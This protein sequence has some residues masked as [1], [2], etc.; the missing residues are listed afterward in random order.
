MNCRY[1]NKI[2]VKLGINSALAAD[3]LLKELMK[4]AVYRDERYWIKCSAKTLSAVFPH[5]GQKAA[6]NALKRL[7]FGGILVRHQYNRKTFDNTY[8]YAFSD[9]GSEMMKNT[10]AN[11]NDYSVTADGYSMPA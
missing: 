1:N 9:Y 4:N 8:F 3:Y 6:S 10:E 11:K 2:A 5:M 7:V